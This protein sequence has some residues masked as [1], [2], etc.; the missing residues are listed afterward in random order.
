M[1]WKYPQPQRQER[2]GNVCTQ[3]R[4]ASGSLRDTL[5]KW[6]HTL[7][8]LQPEAQQ[9]PR[10]Y[11]RPEDVLARGLTSLMITNLPH[12]IRPAHVLKK[13]EDTGFTDRYDFLYLPR[14]LVSGSN[15]GYGFVNF[16]D[17]FSAAE[18]VGR[19]SGQDYFNNPRPRKH[20]VMLPAAVQGFDELVTLCD[21][22]KK[23]HI[24][25]NPSFRPYVRDPDRIPQSL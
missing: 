16:V 2:Q 19:W 17:A 10:D 11:L 22:R 20:L 25:R 6:Q 7:D 14:S 21:I 1:E 12:N 18:F 15:L 5:A 9:A 24:F 23:M 4:V 3:D 13:L 8:D